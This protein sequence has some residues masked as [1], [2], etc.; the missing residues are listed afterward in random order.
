MSSVRS[1][2]E[3]VAGH[4]RLSLEDWLVYTNFHDDNYREQELARFR[5]LR[6]TLRVME[7]NIQELEETLL[8][9]RL[10][11][12]PVY[13]EHMEMEQR[14]TDLL[15]RLDQLRKDRANRTTVPMSS[16][17]VLPPLQVTSAG[18]CQVPPMEEGEISDA[19]VS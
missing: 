11:H 14:E 19:P 15:S 2:N 1:D 10:Q 4:D 12:I 17:I 7:Q 6:E 13:K 18:R 16:P 3:D 9:L 8:Q 5:S